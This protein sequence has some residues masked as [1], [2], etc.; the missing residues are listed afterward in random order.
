MSVSDRLARAKTRLSAYYDAEMAVLS[1]QSYKIGTRSLTRADLGEIRTAITNLENA[2]EELTAQ[3][4]GRGRRL[5][6]QYI[7]VDF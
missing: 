7:P 1:G 4:V 2:V 6:G 5:R 3:A